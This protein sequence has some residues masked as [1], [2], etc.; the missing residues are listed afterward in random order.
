M[1]FRSAGAGG[2][3]RRDA[4]AQFTSM[5]GPGSDLNACHSREAVL[6]RLLLGT[7]CQLSEITTMQ[8]FNMVFHVDKIMLLAAFDSETTWT[9]NRHSLVV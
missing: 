4:P 2:K 8:D 6:A 5:D 9:F 7:M 3:R 1:G